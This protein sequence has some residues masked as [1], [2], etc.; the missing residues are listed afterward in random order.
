M[1]GAIFKEKFEQMGTERVERKGNS[2]QVNYH[3][4]VQV[5]PGCDG[6]LDV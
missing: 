3:G 1:E 5:E 6:L 4:Y 2:R